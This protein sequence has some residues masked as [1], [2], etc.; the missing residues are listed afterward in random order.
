MAKPSCCM[1]RVWRIGRLS[2]RSVGQD[3]EA[4]SSLG[5]AQ[6]RR[7]AVIAGGR[8][9]FLLCRSVLKRRFS[10]ISC[11]SYQARPQHGR[12]T[13]PGVFCGKS[14]WWKN[15][16]KKI[17]FVLS[18]RTLLGWSFYLLLTSFHCFYAL[19][20]MWPLCMDGFGVSIIYKAASHHWK[21]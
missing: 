14:K 21:T 7:F 18:G 6:M 2:E 11:L 4:A 12:D 17:L 1:W 13:G 5:W 20:V 3:S 19:N 9:G 8:Q 10:H 15:A 16:F